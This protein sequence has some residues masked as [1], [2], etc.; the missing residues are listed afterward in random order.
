M[1]ENCYSLFLIYPTF[2]RVSSTITGLWQFLCLSIEGFAFDAGSSP[3]IFCV[4][5]RHTPQ[6]IALSCRSGTRPSCPTEIPSDL[7]SPKVNSGLLII[8]RLK[9]LADILNAS[10]ISYSRCVIRSSS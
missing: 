2:G 1:K 8:R 7:C 4:G 5:S 6:N 3:V 9:A 10:K